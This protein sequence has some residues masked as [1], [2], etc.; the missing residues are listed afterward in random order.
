MTAEPRILDTTRCAMGWYEIEQALPECDLMPNN[1]GVQ[2]LI[3]PPIKEPGC[4]EIRV[5]FYGCRQTDQPNFYMYGR[6]L[7]GITH[8]MPLPHGPKS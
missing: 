4:S 3:W 5:A 6:V 8:W 7:H 2:V 1:F